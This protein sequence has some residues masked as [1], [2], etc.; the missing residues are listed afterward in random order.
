MANLES[1]GITIPETADLTLLDNP[2][3]IELIRH[4]ASLPHEIE[5][6][7]KSYDPAKMTKYAI[8]LA[9]LFHRFYDACSVKNAETDELRSARILLCKAVLQTLRNVL[10]LLNITQPEKM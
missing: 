2:R 6:A 10:T 3:E 5:L 4:I 1:E 7:A 8:D 9:T